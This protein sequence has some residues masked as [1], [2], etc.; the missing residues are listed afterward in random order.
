ME[1]TDGLK[2]YISQKIDMK[3][4]IDSRVPDYSNY[5]PES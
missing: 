2:L 3:C 5:D 4:W 1:K